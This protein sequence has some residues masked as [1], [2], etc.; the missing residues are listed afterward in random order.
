MAERLVGD[1]FTALDEQTVIVPGAEAASLIIPSLAGSLAAVLD[2][3]K[4]LA[5]RIEELLEPTLFPR[6]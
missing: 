1:I 4:L 3:R 6:S 2:Q 5:S